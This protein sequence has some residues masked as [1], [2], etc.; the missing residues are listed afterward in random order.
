MIPLTGDI[1]RRW[2]SP[3]DWNLLCLRSLFKG[4]CMTVRAWSLNPSH[5]FL[6]ASFFFVNQPLACG[7]R[8][9]NPLGEE[10]GRVIPFTYPAVHGLIGL[11]DC[12]HTHLDTFRV[13]TIFIEF[14]DLS[15]R[16][17]SLSCSHEVLRRRKS[18]LQTLPTELESEFQYRS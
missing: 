6:C 13:L 2:W 4:W 3:A 10:S 16:A 12:E 7:F 17:L 5:R 14:V 8:P 9:G 1:R 18:H 11:T 15:Y